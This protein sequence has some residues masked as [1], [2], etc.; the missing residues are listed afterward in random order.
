V[1]VVT[2]RLA[3]QEFIAHLFAPVDGPYADLARIQIAGIW[4]QCRNELAM[5]EPINGVA[6]LDLP[7]EW[8]GA[9][10][11][12]VV[13]GQ[14]DLGADRQAI[15]RRSYDV[16]NLSVVFASPIGGDRPLRLRPAAPPGWVDYAGWWRR[17]AAHGTGAMLGVVMIFQAK[18]PTADTDPLTLSGE[19]REALPAGDDAPGWWNSG[20]RLREGFALWEATPAGDGASRRLV[21]L[22]GPGEDAALSDLTWSDGSVTIPPLGR[23]LMHAAKLRYQSR[24]R[25][26]GTQLRA[27]RDQISRRLG[28]RP[29]PEQALD[30]NEQD[31]AATLA[32]LR[33]LQRSATIAVAN[34]GQA[35]APPLDSDRV[36][37]TLL[38]RIPDDLAYLEILAERLKT[39]RPVHAER[40]PVQIPVHRSVLVPPAPP[41]EREVEDRLDLRLC[42]AVDI[43]S[44]SSRSGPARTDLQERLDRVLRR[45]RDRLKVDRDRVTEQ[46]QGDA[47]K[48]FFPTEQLHHVLPDIVDHLRRE[49]AADNERFKDR[50]RLRAATAVGM[51]GPATIGLAGELVVE[52]HRLV[53]S[54][55]LRKAAQNH[56]AADLV[57]L[58][59]GFLHHLVIEPG[60]ARMPPGDLQPCRVKV[61]EHAERAWLWTQR[62]APD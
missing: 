16:L 60:W 12:I 9:G 24:V 20:R 13:A 3:E 55:Q 14:Q 48:L 34:M 19:V 8:P 35:Y 18:A 21:V 27:L 11:F 58:V 38:A 17:L 33:E 6:D 47:M 28:Q 15:L 57:L 41:P 4:Q 39:A 52:A 37:E 31:L 25:G 2:G 36:A 61:K 49:V 32:S 5:T 29:L 50:M 26:D 45:V 10:P 54:S 23:Y 44:F 56:P 1:G 43:V 30:Q 62:A 22:A 51:M 7:A 59:S 53:D 46:P 40:G 42:L